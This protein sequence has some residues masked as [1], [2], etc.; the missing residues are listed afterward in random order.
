M[1]FE[2]APQ[3]VVQKLSGVESA[4]V[5]LDKASADIT[6]KPENRIT[7][8]QLRE[9]LKKNGYPTRDAQLE[10]R[11]RIVEHDGK[12][13][14]DLLNGSTLEIDPKG[15]PVTASDPIVQITGVSRADAKAGE[16]LT[17]QT[18]K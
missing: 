13:M 5:S 4:G 6:L 7:M 9:V 17:V 3:N 11:G 10:L 14:V 8:T 18:V 16:R 2:E 12:L 15:A 1:S